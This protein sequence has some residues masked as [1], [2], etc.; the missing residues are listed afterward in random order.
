M[1][2]NKFMALKSFFQWLQESSPSTRWRD[3]WGRYGNYPLSASVMSR[4]TPMP[5]IMDKA[6]K[7]LGMPHKKK[8]KRKKRKKI[9][10]NKL[11]IKPKKD[12]KPIPVTHDDFDKWLKSLEGLAEDL[13]AL[14]NAKK[15]FKEKIDSIKEKHKDGKEDKQISDKDKSDREKSKEEKDEQGKSKKSKRTGIESDKKV[16][17]PVSFITYDEL[18]KINKKLSKD[19]EKS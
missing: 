16:L 9:D 8:R 5:Y 2:L 18:L 3:G 12:S 14:E 7:E 17:P 6:I 13:K 10:E 15:K 4:S 19:K 1:G 11:F